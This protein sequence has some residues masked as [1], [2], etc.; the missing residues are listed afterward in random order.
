VKEER[1]L[2]IDNPP[3]GRLF[4]IVLNNTYTAHP[5]KILPIGSMADLEAATIEDVREFHDIYYLPSNATVVVSGDFDPKQTVQWIEKYFGNIPTGK[6]IQREVAAE[7]KQ[8]AERRATDYGQSTPL[9][10]VVMT[11]HIPE[12]KNA[13]M[14][15]LEVASNILSGGESSRL[16]K[17]MVYEKQ[18]AV[19]ANG[20][21]LALED[22][23]VFFFFSILQ[24]G[25]KPEDGEKELD[26]EIAKLRSQPVS[27]DELVKAKNQ[28][29]SGLV[30]G[31]DTVSD[32]GTAIGHASVILQDLS[33]ANR[34]L[35]EF[36]KV[37][38]ADVQRVARTYF[39]PTNRTVVYMLPESMRPADASAK[40]EVKP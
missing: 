24:S 14:A 18:M 9:P 2:R 27:D 1:R 38:A 20:Q 12:E 40:G 33:L 16:Y 39:Q 7:P 28:L 8:L 5:Y 13:D 15:A 4:E 3:F 30:F 10:A 37:T 23:G 19:A 17:K 36:Q 11:Y 34:Q 31:R 22:P 21:V 26:E 25:V 32:K 29:I 35:A 6:P